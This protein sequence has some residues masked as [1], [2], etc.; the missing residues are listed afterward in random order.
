[1]NILAVTPIR[2]GTIIAPCNLGKIPRLISELVPVHGAREVN[3]NINR[4]RLQKMFVEKYFGL[5]DFVLLLDSDVAV[6]FQ[7]VQLLVDAWKPGTVPC[8]NTKGIQTDHV[9]ASCALISRADY[10]NV[11]YVTNPYTCQCM[12]LPN[13][14]YVKGALAKEL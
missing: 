1:M 9:V 6:D 3:I 10:R 5:Y 2:P 7:T 8:T 13:T 11:D 4:A 12:K 14:F